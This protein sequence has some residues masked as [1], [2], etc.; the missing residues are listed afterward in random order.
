MKE[1]LTKI[2]RYRRDPDGAYKRSARVHNRARAAAVNWLKLEHPEVWQQLLNAQWE[3][4]GGA[5]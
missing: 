2:E 1:P 3:K 4:E 5:A